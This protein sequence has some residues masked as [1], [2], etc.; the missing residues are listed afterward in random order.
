MPYR[1]RAYPCQHL[2]YG[3]PV[4]RNCKSETRK[5]VILEWQGRLTVW[6]KDYTWLAKS[7]THTT[8]NRTH[9]QLS[10]RSLVKISMQTTLR[11][12][13]FI[14]ET[15]YTTQSM[16]LKHSRNF[17]TPLDHFDYQMIAREAFTVSITCVNKPNDPFLMRW[18]K[19]PEHA[20]AESWALKIEIEIN[21]SQYCIHRLL[22]GNREESAGDILHATSWTGITDSRLYAY[23]EIHRHPGDVAGSP[24]CG[25]ADFNND[26]ARK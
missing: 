14:P 8:I 10:F 5:C 3:F 15:V 25:V 21:C 18:A 19:R 1:F 23:A 4:F 2:S 6:W 7:I 16:P 13:G 9:S 20:R 17:D 26:G 22:S 24:D 11:Y 12:Y